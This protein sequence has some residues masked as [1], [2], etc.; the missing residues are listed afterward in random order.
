METEN[1]ILSLAEVER[2]HVLGTL[3]FCAGNRTHTADILKISLRG[4]R[5]KLRQYEKSGFYVC[6]PLRGTQ[7]R[8]L[9][10]GTQRDLRG[11][12]INWAD[13]SFMSAVRP[14]GLNLT[15]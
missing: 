4:L 6:R 8:A 10:M 2:Q 3:I 1:Y 9:T 5:D 14:G 7:K 11:R 12:T 15:P 13:G